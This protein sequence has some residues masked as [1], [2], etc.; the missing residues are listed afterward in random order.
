MRQFRR[1]HLI[2]VALLFVAGC[3]D[4]DLPTQ[5]VYAGN[6]LHSQ[7][8]SRVDVCHVNGD[9]TYS[10]I[11]VADAAYSS[12]VDHGDQ[13]PGE[14]VPGRP[15][16]VFDAECRMVELPSTPIGSG[17]G[18]VVAAD[19]AVE[20]DFPVNA[21]NEDLDIIVQAVSD[22]LSSPGMVPGLVFRFLPSGTQF[23]APVTLTV[24]Y[25]PAT[26]G[27][28]DPTALRIQKLVGG[29]WVPVEGSTVNT[30]D[31]TVTAT[32]SSFSVYGVGVTVHRVPAVTVTSLSH[33]FREG[34]EWDDWDTTRY[35]GDAVAFHSHPWAAGS[36]LSDGFTASIGTG[37]MVVVR[38]QAPSGYRFQVTRH[39]TAPTQRF[40]SNV[41]WHTGISV[42]NEYYVSAPLS[43]A[44]ENLEGPAP[45]GNYAHAGLS[46]TGQAVKVEYSAIV[47][48]DLSFTA[49]EFWFTVSHSVNAEPRTYSAVASNSDPS[50]SVF[51]WGEGIRDGTLMAL[52]PI[53]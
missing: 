50:F 1:R 2:P 21:L 49:V 51:A 23:G 42:P 11:T 35:I 7:S 10:R 6:P 14:D 18:T 46:T 33:S 31:N 30:A 15:G 4:H 22:P 53:R 38:I 19:G 28:L 45:Q 5:P 25:D 17:G 24:Q 29:D 37:E 47:A 43:V 40:H 27:T 8:Q 32:L 12:H 3:S 9:G 20:F 26:L 36:Y 44:F 41:Y 39:R 34:N 13:S 52:V 48:N 16:H